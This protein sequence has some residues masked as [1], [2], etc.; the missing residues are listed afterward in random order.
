M[1]RRGPSLKSGR[2]AGSQQRQLQSSTTQ[3][4][5]TKTLG[6]CDTDF[7]ESFEGTLHPYVPDSLP[8]PDDYKHGFIATGA[9]NPPAQVCPHTYAFLA[10]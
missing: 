1:Y 6:N 10:R 8:I 9:T 7:R 4:L 3:A 5:T 2:M